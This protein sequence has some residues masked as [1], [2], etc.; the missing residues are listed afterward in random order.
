MIFF[1]FFFPPTIHKTPCQ[2]P[3]KI[4]YSESAFTAEQ[5]GVDP[6]FDSK[7]IEKA[8]GG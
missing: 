5:L 6:K 7:E 1:C 8:M 2:D 3:S 4:E